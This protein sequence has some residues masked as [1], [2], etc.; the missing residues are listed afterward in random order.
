MSFNVS[1]NMAYIII[2][3]SY[4][5]NYPNSINSA[6]ILYAPST[7]KLR[8]DIKDFQLESGYDFA[9]V[10]NGNVLDRNAIWQRS[11]ST[12]LRAIFSQSEAMWVV[13]TSDSSVTRKGFAFYVKSVSEFGE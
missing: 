9:T 4:P 11:G 8:L 7:M 2:S 5:S 13:F 12:N 3:P 6:W 1:R 10:G